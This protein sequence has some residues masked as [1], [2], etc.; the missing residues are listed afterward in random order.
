VAACGAGT[1][2]SPFVQAEIGRALRQREAGQTRIL[3]VILKAGVRLPAGLDFSIQAIHYS[4]LFPSIVWM[5]AAIA[6]AIVGL[7]VVAGV[8]ARQAWISDLQDQIAL[9]AESQHA[10]TDLERVARLER[11]RSSALMLVFPEGLRT[12]NTRLQRAGRPDHRQQWLQADAQRITLL[13]DPSENVIWMGYETRIEALHATTREVVRAY[14]LS[15]FT[16]DALAPGSTHDRAPAP[17]APAKLKDLRI[18]PRVRGVLATV[19]FEDYAE[20]SADE[21]QDE[22]GGG[23]SEVLRLAV[24]LERPQSVGLNESIEWYS[25]KAPDGLDY[26]E[27]YF[28]VH[29]TADRVESVLSTLAERDL[30]IVRAAAGANG[31]EDRAYLLAL[32]PATS[33]ALFGFEIRTDE[34]MRDYFVGLL[35]PNGEFRRIGV[36]TQYYEHARDL[37]VLARAA[38]NLEGE[39]YDPGEV[40]PFTDVVPTYE[41]AALWLQRDVA[42]IHDRVVPLS[43]SS[44]TGQQP[45][46]KEAIPAN[47]RI[48]DVRWL[49]SGS[50]LRF[51]LNDGSLCVCLIDGTST[52]HRFLRPT[53]A[54][55]VDV[56]PDGERALVLDASGNIHAWQLKSFGADG[57]IR[58]AS[59]SSIANSL[60]P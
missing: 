16:V 30:S 20:P 23:E 17:R 51:A 39:D 13:T 42:W 24:G 49:A 41:P 58:F 46:L 60:R 36:T 57:W 18:D 33:A 12:I 5:R 53:E 45:P 31:A 50:A 38:R 9:E 56:T 11:L 4:V 1:A 34:S 55:A 35:L 52:C 22:V 7:I 44:N 59:S 32:D 27:G 25:P 8:F 3:P 15:N 26:G 37:D 43:A 28:E 2:A 6:A 14:D 21:P 47:T 54:R 40:T 29:D 10:P 19:Q 48:I